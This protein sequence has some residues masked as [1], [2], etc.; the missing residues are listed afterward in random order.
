MGG[1][2]CEEGGPD[3][4]G[5]GLDHHPERGAGSQDRGLPLLW[6]LHCPAGHVDA[7]AVPHLPHMGGPGTQPTWPGCAQPAYYVPHCSHTVWHPGQVGHGVWV[8]LGQM[9]YTFI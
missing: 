7:V 1:G 5:T 4:S 6:H 9:G 3:S 2:G 8:Y